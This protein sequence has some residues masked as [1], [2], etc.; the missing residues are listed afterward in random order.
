MVGFV[1]HPRDD[2][3]QQSAR[4]LFSSPINGQQSKLGVGLV[5][6]H[7]IVMVGIHPTRLCQ[8]VEQ[9]VQN[10]QA[11]A[12]CRPILG[13]AIDEFPVRDVV[14]EL[15]H[16]HGSFGKCPDRF[17]S[18]CVDHVLLAIASHHLSPWPS[19]VVEKGMS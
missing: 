11:I 18:G 19:A 3:H 17:T 2:V 12:P 10:D 16:R 15:R 6:E 7:D 9:V 1:L 13:N 14:A 5:G 8:L 4:L